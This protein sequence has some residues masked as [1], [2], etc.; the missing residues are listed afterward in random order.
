MAGTRRTTLNQAEA[1][2]FA[3]IFALNSLEHN[4]N[5]PEL[6]DRLVPLLRPDGVFILSGPTESGFY[7]L[8][9]RLAGF[10]GH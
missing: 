4:E 1:N 8:G 2:S 3:A 5:I 9:R 7:R 10:S 6:V